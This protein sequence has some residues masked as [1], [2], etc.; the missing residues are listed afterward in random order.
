MSNGMAQSVERSS[1]CLVSHCE[2]WYSRSQFRAPPMPACM[3][4]EENSLAA[5]LAAK[6]SAGVKP[7]VNLREHVTCM[8]QPN[9]NKAAHSG[10]ETQRRCHQKF[11]TGVSVTPQKGLM[12]SKIFF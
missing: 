6:R 3:Y 4:M 8:P 10:F 1:T 5:K 9:A 2:W 11:K 7:E 12:S